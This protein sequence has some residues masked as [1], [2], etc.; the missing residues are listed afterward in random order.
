MS[1]SELQIGRIAD[2]IQGLYEHLI[3]ENVPKD[4]PCKGLFAPDKAYAL[5]KQGYYKWYRELM[6]AVYTLPRVS[7]I[8][9]EFGIMDRGRELLVQLAQQKSAQTPIDIHRMAGEWIATIDI[10]FE[11]VTS[12][13]PI[14]GLA[15]QQPL[16]AGDVTFWPLE[17]VKAQIKDSDPWHSF[18]A[19][20]PHMSCVASMRTRT[21]PQRSI[22]ILREK[23]EYAANVFRYIGTTIFQEGPTMPIYA[24]ENEPNR[25]SRAVTID[26]GG[27]VC[28]YSNSVQ[29]PLPLVL[30]AMNRQTADDYG[31]GHLLSLLGK[32]DRSPLEDN[33]L[34][35]LQWFGDASQDISAAFSF[36]KFYISL[37]TVS[38]EDNESARSVLPSRVSWLLSPWDR[39]RRSRISKT[40]ERV[41]EERNAVFHGGVPAG[42]SFEYL[43]RVSK[44]MAR[45]T[46]HEVRQLVERNCLKTKD[47]LIGWIKQM[48]PVRHR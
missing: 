26:A 11:E 3:V 29:S 44:L 7:E 21:E 25:E 15:L 16:S 27:R 22:E 47:E 9:S 5:D 45:A 10:Q 31:L 35:A 37:E 40:V 13:V 48:K 30:N 43:Q 6:Q 24:L 1:L 2:S 8:W 28:T 17:T 42:E 39:G 32:S 18:D 19:L 38:K 4:A 14:V 34:T 23:A 33:L 20:S 12:Y 36:V 41:I 46:I